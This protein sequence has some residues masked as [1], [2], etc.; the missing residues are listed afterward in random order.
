MA[1]E[2][3]AVDGVLRALGVPE[4]TIQRAA[5]RGDPPAALFESMPVRGA[6]ERTVS[7][8]AIE[9]RGGMPR[10]RAAEPRLKE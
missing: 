7:A 9:T 3:E 5:G 6:T 4:E 2:P 8:G 10:S 1:S